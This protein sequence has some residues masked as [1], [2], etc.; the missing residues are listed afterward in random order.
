M[1]TRLRKLKVTK[2]ALVSQGANQQAEVLLF[3][4]AAVA[5][6]DKNSDGDDENTPP[7]TTAQTLQRQQLWEQWQPLWQ[8]FCRSVYE[9]LEYGEHGG[10]YVPLLLQSIEEFTAQAT[11]LLAGLGLTAKAAPLFLECAEVRKAGAVMAASRKQ[12]LQAAIAALQA[13]LDEAEPKSAEM[14]TTAKGDAM[15][16]EEVTKRAEAAEGRVAAL[17]AELATV[18]KAFSALKASTKPPPTEEDFLKSLPES[19]RKRWESNELRLQEAE[20]VAKAE[21]AQR[22]QQEYIAKTAA[23]RAVGVA[24]DDWDVLK[25]IDGLDDKYRV[26]LLHLLKSADAAIKHSAL[27]GEIGTAGGS[28]GGDAYAVIEALATELSKGG[29]LTKAQAIVKALDARPDLMRQYHAERK[30]AR[31]G[32]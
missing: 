26:R 8:A 19:L 27:F 29:T 22:E 13:I 10:D 12:R 30:E 5:R 32:R 23:Y 6:V 15:T 24:P 25:A 3:K 28:G 16:L 14:T 1:T 7:L 4:S 31:N 9:I 11:N 2:I 17:E 21:K 18:T 20:A